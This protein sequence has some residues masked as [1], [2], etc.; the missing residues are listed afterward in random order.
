VTVGR[1]I[2]VAYKH[3]YLIFKERTETVTAI[4]YLHMKKCKENYIIGSREQ[5][6]KS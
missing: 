3:T 4:V 6:F 1:Q 5:T 2:F